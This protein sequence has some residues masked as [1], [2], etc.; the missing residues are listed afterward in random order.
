MTR[1]N[2]AISFWTLRRS[3]V[4]P[5]SNPRTPH[6]TIRLDNVN[7]GSRSF[8]LNV[9][10]LALLESVNAKFRSAANRHQGI[11]RPHERYKPVGAGDGE[12]IVRGGVP[13][14]NAGMRVN[15][16]ER[17]EPL[18]S[19]PASHLGSRVAPDVYVTGLSHDVVTAGINNGHDNRISPEATPTPENG[20]LHRLSAVLPE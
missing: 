6:V 5:R 16:R 19:K 7:E 4:R 12:V 3:T 2:L 8:A 13:S 9:D 14:P 20:T 11:V 15:L 17:Y 18:G 1:E 10:P